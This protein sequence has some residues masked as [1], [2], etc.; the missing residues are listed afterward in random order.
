M[1]RLFGLLLLLTLGCGM[2]A[3]EAVELASSRWQRA[4][5]LTRPLPDI[6]ERHGA[7]RCRGH[8]VSGCWNSATQTLTLDVDSGILEWLAAHEWGHVLG[9]PDGRPGMLMC[10]ERYCSLP[11]IT[12][13]DVEIVCDGPLGPCQVE[14]PEYDALAPLTRR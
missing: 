10:H 14:D 4:T 8:L 11:L 13:H 1:R 12:R 5:G 2:S 9:A 3:T 7:F 6:I